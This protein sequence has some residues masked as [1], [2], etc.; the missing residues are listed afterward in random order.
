MAVK[1]LDKVVQDGEKE[2]KTKVH[3]IARTHHR[4]LVQLIGYHDNSEYRLLVYEYV[5]NDTLVLFGVTRP[6]WKQRS[7][8]VSC[9]AKGPS[10]LYE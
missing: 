7:H 9:I 3:A 5:S 2:F 1:K 6:N 10:Y 4:N 8:V